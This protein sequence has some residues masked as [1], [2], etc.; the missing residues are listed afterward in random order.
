MIDRVHN[1]RGRAYNEHIGE[2]AAASP[3]KRQCGNGSLY[4]AATVVK[5]LPRQYAWALGASVGQCGDE[6]D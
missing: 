3:Q 6:I 1:R 4:P 2:I 5:P